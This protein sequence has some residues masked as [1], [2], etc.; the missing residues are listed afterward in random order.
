MK[1]TFP[2]KVHVDVSSD[3]SG[4][5]YSSCAGHRPSIFLKASHAS[6]PV[7]TEAEKIHVFDRK[8][9]GFVLDRVTFAQLA[10]KQRGCLTKAQSKP[11]PKR[12]NT[13]KPPS[14]HLT[15]DETLQFVRE[16]AKKS[17]EKE[18]KKEQRASD[19]KRGLKLVKLA[20]Q[21]LAKKGSK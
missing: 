8:L 12:A 18:K 3:I 15:S 2:S 21:N 7:Y 19:I 17:E 4:E 5:F 13:N 14:L 9:L 16:K 10:F 11:Q 20:Q 6:E 1:L